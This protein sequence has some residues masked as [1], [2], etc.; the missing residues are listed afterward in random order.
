MNFFA[1]FTDS[2]CWYV[3]SIVAGES[4]QSLFILSIT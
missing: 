3:V 4:F 1:E 2:S